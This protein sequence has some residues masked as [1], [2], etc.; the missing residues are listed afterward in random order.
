MKVLIPTPNEEAGFEGECEDMLNYLIEHLNI[1]TEDQD[2]RAAL[3][4]HIKALVTLAIAIAE[5]EYHV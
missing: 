2:A 1:A 4:E 5:A 3:K